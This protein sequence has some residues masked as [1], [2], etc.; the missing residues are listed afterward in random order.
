MPGRSDVAN[1]LTAHDALPHRR[2][3]PR[4]VRV[5]AFETEPVRD[6]HQVAVAARIEAG[7]RDH[8]NPSGVDRGP[9]RLREV[10][11]GVPAPGR[12]PAEPVADRSRDRV[13]K[14]H[15]PDGRRR[16]HLGS[17]QGRDRRRARDSI[18]RDVRS[19]L[20]TA[21]R[22]CCVR[23]EAP[24]EPTRLEA[25]LVQQELERRD[26]PATL[27]LAHRPSAER[28]LAPPPE[29][30]PG[31]RARD[32]VHGQ[33]ALRLKGA[34]GALRPRT[35]DAVHRMGIEPER[36][37]RDLQGGDVRAPGA[38]CGGRCEEQSRDRPEQGEELG[39]S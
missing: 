23:P 29:R 11:A 15:G 12:D 33:A 14:A 26:I 1:R 21:H 30:R 36:V 38:G 24:V 7:E 2:G 6:H 9:H 10:E 32:P 19:R 4:H 18:D 35:A 28:G 3:D 17:A 22:G 25:P 27:S 34:N 16:D 39:A 37:H 20:E 31:L 13:E 8:P 5:P